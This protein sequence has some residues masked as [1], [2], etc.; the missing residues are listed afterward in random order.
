MK[1][2]KR[3]WA[4]ILTAAFFATGANSHAFPAIDDQ[5]I[6]KL[7]TQ[8]IS[9]G[10]V[11]VTVEIADSPDSRERGLMYRK[12]MPAQEGML[13]IFEEPQPMAFWMKNTLIP[14][15]IGYF[16]AGKKLINIY[17]MSPAV[18]GEMHPK[19]YP[20]GGDALYALEMNKGWFDKHHIKPGAELHILRAA[21]PNH[22]PKVWRKARTSDL[23]RATS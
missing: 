18:V 22:S 10:G 5:T 3:I 13:F 19:T 15:S 9:I 16:S 23:R 6:E 2:K 21:Q 12:S 8:K 1:R 4:F 11:T 20:S 14:L 7:K 17:E